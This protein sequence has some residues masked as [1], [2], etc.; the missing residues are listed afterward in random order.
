MQFNTL[1][2]IP[3]TKERVIIINVGTR[4]V[5]TLAILS[6]ICKT[7]MPVLL[8]DCKLLDNDPDDYSYFKKIMKEYEFDIVSMPLNGHGIT[9][10]YIFNHLKS[11]YILLMDSDLELLDKTIVSSMQKDI[12][13]PNIFGAG[14]KHGGFWI[15]SGIDYEEPRDGY[16]QERVWIPFVLLNVTY[17]KEALN[18]G[19]SFSTDVFYN[20][21]P[22]NQ[23]ISKRLL[24]SKRI[25]KLF[26]FLKHSDFR[27][28]DFLKKEIHHKKPLIIFSDTGSLI[29]MYLRYQKSYYFSG[30]DAESGLETDFVKHYNGIT[31][32]LLFDD[33]FNTGSVDKEYEN[34]K[35]KL[36]KEYKFDY[37]LF[38]KKTE[39]Q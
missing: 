38:N 31:R 7:N 23:R 37:E 26:P 28:L 21:I 15:K 30:V 1:S 4:F 2:D 27:F 32:K 14:F 25:L 36:L 24:F 16:Y 39:N 34:I 12:L 9:L 22:S 29:Y 10:D 33:S 8:I 19:L 6:A 17:V 3:Y 11:D 5:T 20:I 35:N 13:K 18:T